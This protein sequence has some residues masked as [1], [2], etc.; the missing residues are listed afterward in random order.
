MRPGTDVRIL[1]WVTSNFTDD[2][3]KAL[4]WLNQ[5]TAEEIEVY[6][7]EVRA[8]KIGDSLPAH[9]FHPVVFADAWSKRAQRALTGLSPSAQR[10]YE[11]F[12]PLVE[13]LWNAGFTNQTTARTRGGQSF[14]TGH[15]GITY[16]VGF[17]WG[18]A[19]VHIWISAGE[20]SKSV[21][22]F[23]A[24]LKHEAELQTE[25][26]GLQF[27]LIGQ[28]G[29]RHRVSAG[30]SRD[31]SLN[32]PDDGLQEV[33]QWMFDNLIAIKTTFQP[34]LEAVMTKLQAEQ[35]AAE[36][37]ASEDASAAAAEVDSQRQPESTDDGE[38]APR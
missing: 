8:I 26:P 32:D 31:G 25:L 2:H 4:E 34:H 16:N 24:L 13:D 12:Q 36:E 3:R 27:D 17:G 10:H 9:R 22:I 28:L 6:G 15:P 38:T 35:S 23:D 20:P 37:S 11:F 5:W 33:R 30:M 29:G 1:V 7:V 18:K 14:A 21:R 19:L